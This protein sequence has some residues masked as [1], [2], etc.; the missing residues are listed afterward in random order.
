LLK[1]KDNLLAIQ[2]KHQLCNGFPGEIMPGVVGS[3][4]HILS[5]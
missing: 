5:G 3:S 1:V 4:M 2:G